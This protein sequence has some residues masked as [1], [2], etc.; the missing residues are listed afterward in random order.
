MKI[1]ISNDDGWGAKGLSALIRVLRPMG[2]IIVVAPN[3]PRSGQSNAMT[4]GQPVTL[5]LI[6]SEPGLRI[7]S[8]SGTPT[9]CVKI[10][11]DQLY[12]DVKPALVCS[13][14]NHGDN[15]TINV[16]YSGTMGAV[17]D[18]TVHNIPAIGWSICTHDPDADFSEMERW[19]PEVLRIIL[20]QPYSFGSCWNVNAPVGPIRGI[21]FTRHCRGMWEKE[22][23][24]VDPN[25]EHMTFN[26][27]GTYVNLEPE[28]EDTDQYACAHNYISVC[29]ANTDMTDYTMLRMLQDQA[30]DQ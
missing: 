9:D 13:G 22:W 1:L 21:R 28:A 17:F 8:C 30:D 4:I 19:I 16:I 24:V 3:G 11:I 20:K 15:G 18:G 29:P 10:A 27:I 25:P 14:I 12:G 6:S 23:E 2:E 7:Y 26:L 5:D